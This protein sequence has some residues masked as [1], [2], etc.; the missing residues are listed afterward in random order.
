MTDDFLLGDSALHQRLCAITEILARFVAAAPRSLSLLQLVDG[1][2]RP[3]RE[4][5]RLC[6][7]LDR[8]GLLRRH[9]ALPDTW[10][11]LCAPDQVTLEDVFKGVMADQPERPKFTEPVAAAVRRQHRLHHDADL[12]VMQAAMAINQS[13]FQ[14]LRQ[15]S[16]DRLKTSASITFPLHAGRSTALA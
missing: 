10:E 3:E 12:L 2:G 16:L 6:G 4:L 11:L 7:A 9:A 1:I 5:N 15:F 13:V 8:A 14:H